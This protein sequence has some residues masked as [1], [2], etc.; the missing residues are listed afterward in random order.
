MSDQGQVDP[1]ARARLAAEQAVGNQIDRFVGMAATKI[2]DVLFGSDSEYDKKMMDDYHDKML[3]IVDKAP[4]PRD[5]TSIPNYQD[6][7][8][9]ERAKKE[10]EQVQDLIQKSKK[11]LEEAKNISRC[12]VCKADLEETLRVVDE[13]T[14]DIVISNAKVLAM[15]R[16]KERGE[17]PPSIKW[18][19]LDK[20]Q[21]KLVDSEVIL[22]GG[23]IKS[24]KRKYSSSKKS[25]A[26]PRKSASTAKSSGV[27]SKKPRSKK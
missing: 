23:V 15:Q 7:S 2:I 5:V 9:S 16:L 1:V 8:P 10:I 20:S 3:T 12:G 6:L 24:A 19:D 17:L 26:T 11:S 18:D 21:R 4:L 13:K 25:T 14:E 22:S 27:K